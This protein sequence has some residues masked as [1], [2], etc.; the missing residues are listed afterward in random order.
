[1]RWIS[2]E[3]DTIEQTL[4]AHR[5]QQQAPD[6]F[7]YDVTSSYVEGQQNELAA[8]GYNRDGKKGKKQIVVG[9][10]C[11][12][13]GHPVSV[14][15]F[16]GNIQDTQTFLQ[17]IRKVGERFG[18]SRVTFVGDRGMI[19]QA[20]IAALSVEGFQYITAI[21]KPQDSCSHQKETV[22]ITPIPLFF[23]GIDTLTSLY[24][25]GNF[26][27]NER[28]SRRKRYMIWL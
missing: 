14:Q 7:L 10:L 11:D 3:Q 28:S 16:R 26:R 4:F 1:M 2:Q 18:C 23:L 27:E 9:L 15:V 24:S 20:G 21:A 17:Q 6:L 22:K 13:T 12:A 5:S 19:K 8:Y 25:H